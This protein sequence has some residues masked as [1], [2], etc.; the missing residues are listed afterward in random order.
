MKRL[1][2]WSPNYVCSL[3]NKE[4]TNGWLTKISVFFSLQFAVNCSNTNV[5]QNV[6]KRRTYCEYQRLRQESSVYQGF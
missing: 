6:H 4:N 1:L 2:D 3:S 5:F